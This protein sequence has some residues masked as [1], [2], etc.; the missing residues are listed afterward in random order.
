MTVVV[1]C[2]MIC[3]FVCL[4]FMHCMW[5]CT[6][7][8][9]CVLSCVTFEHVF[10]VKAWHVQLHKEFIGFRVFF[11]MEISCSKLNFL[12]C[13]HRE[14][15]KEAFDFFFFNITFIYTVSRKYVLFP[16]KL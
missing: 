3:K 4:V 7:D 8:P 9:L 16:S 12:C 5:T 6:C 10:T 15:E 14:R 2:K 11:L 13:V 1:L